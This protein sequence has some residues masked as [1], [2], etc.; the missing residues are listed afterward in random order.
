[1]KKYLSLFGLGLASCTPSVEKDFQRIPI[2]FNTVENLV[3]HIT[4]TKKYIYW[5]CIFKSDFEQTSKVIASKGD[6]SSIKDL[7]YDVPKEGF[8]YGNGAGYYY[9]AYY[10]KKKLAYAYDPKSLQ[11]FIGKIDDL[12]EALLIAETQNFSVDFK[13]KFGSSYKKTPTGFELYLAQH[14]LCPTQ[15]EAFKILINTLGNLEAKTSNYFYNVHKNV[16]AD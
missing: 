9:I 6:S 13:K 3:R 2:E 14:H 15:S 11:A 4:P 1:M 10:D 7:R 16:C 5:E 12:P 8:I